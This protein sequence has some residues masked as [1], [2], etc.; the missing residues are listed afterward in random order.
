MSYRIHHGISHTG[1]E[2]HHV[3]LAAEYDLLDRKTNA[4][5]TSELIA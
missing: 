3:Q 2:F 1:A 4:Q 5:P